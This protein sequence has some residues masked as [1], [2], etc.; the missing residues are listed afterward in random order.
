MKS[1]P[2][3]EQLAEMTRLLNNARIENWL[4]EGVGSWRWWV[5][6]VLIF[7]PWFIWVKVSRQEETP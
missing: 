7:A 1:Y 5:L 4:G 2:T 6:V 3:V